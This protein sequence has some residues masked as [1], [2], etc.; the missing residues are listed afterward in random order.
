MNRTPSK[1]TVWIALLLGVVGSAALAFC[2][3]YVAKADT[4]LFNESSKVIIARDGT[5]TILTMA[6]DYRG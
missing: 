5:R 2:G 1:K 4:T 6:N 3:F